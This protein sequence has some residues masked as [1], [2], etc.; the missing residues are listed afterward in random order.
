MMCPDRCVF[1][2]AIRFVGRLAFINPA[3][4]SD[5]AHGRGTAVAERAWASRVVRWTRQSVTPPLRGT[6]ADLDEAPYCGMRRTMA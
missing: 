4:D 1:D 2:R 3:I 5:G 6:F